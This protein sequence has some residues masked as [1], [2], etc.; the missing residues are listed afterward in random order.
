MPDFLTLPDPVFLVVPS[1]LAQ[2]GS[3]MVAGESQPLTNRY[4]PP[5]VC[6][7]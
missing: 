5:V 1:I 6:S 3:K 4:N 7:R 2:S